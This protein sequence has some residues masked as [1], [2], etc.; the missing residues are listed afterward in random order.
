MP[1]GAKVKAP[2]GDYYNVGD[3]IRAAWVAKLGPDMLTDIINSQLDTL[4]EGAKV[5]INGGQAALNH[6]M[7]TFH[8]HD[9]WKRTSKLRVGRKRNAHDHLHHLLY[10]CSRT[11]AL[12]DR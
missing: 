8:P 1:D 3:V 12:R 6:L 7:T 5:A 9:T 11:A 4:V 10:D 2:G